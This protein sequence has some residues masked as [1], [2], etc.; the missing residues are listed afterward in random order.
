MRVWSGIALCALLFI[1]NAKAESC[2]FNT[3]VKCFIEV[4]DD[5][6]WT[7][8]ELKSNVV[9]ITEDKCVHLR[10]LEKC[11]SDRGENVHGCTHEEI[12]D[13]SRTVS[14]LLTHRK[15]SGT[16]LTSYY[17]LNF[18]CSTKGQAMLADNREC[19]T[20]E[21]IGEMTMSAATYLTDKFIDNGKLTT[22]E[23]CHE[24]NYKLAEYQD[25]LNPMCE[26]R[27]AEIMC[28]S[29]LGLF[30]G[31]HSKRLS[32]CQFHQCGP[33]ASSGEE[34]IP[35]VDGEELDNEIT[36]A[37][38]GVDDPDKASGQS[39]VSVATALLMVAL[40]LV[41]IGRP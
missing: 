5:W 35:P 18:A 32:G 24:L 4:L 17:L 1:V 7:L 41:T 30:K 27:A 12:L 13:A 11:V 2:D 28:E 3:L 15:H 34:V 19:L 22:D 21:R 6:A 20:N 26:G 25:A 9:T 31:V 23:M 40:S 38:N 8:F 39:A 36:A 29:L 10:E 33:K 14:D 37:Q 16:F